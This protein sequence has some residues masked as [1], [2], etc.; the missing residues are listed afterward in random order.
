MKKIVLALVVLTAVL[1][2]GDFEDG[3]KA[4]DNKD[5]K[6]ATALWNKAA[7]EGDARAQF[8]IG[9]MSEGNHNH[10]KALKLYKQSCDGGFSI[11][12]DYYKK[13]NKK[14]DA[15]SADNKTFTVDGLKS[16]MSRDEIL[17]LKFKKRD[18]GQYTVLQGSTDMVSEMLYG[19]E[20]SGDFLAYESEILGK[21]A[22]VS[23]WFTTKTKLLYSARV[24][25]QGLGL[26]AMKN[27]GFMGNV[28]KVLTK[29][30][31]KGKTE[32]KKGK[33][34]FLPGTVWK[35][36]GQ[37]KITSRISIGAGYSVGVYINYLDSKLQ[38]QNENEKKSFVETTDKL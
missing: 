25:W 26:D 36:N 3:K 15:S 14:N 6:K 24:E 17:P 10:E 31:G 35:P 7:K 8:N 5:Y 32:I 18:D 33:E 30:Y 1:F 2:A 22:T 37:T 20:Q 19:K 27:T 11:G 9:F 28:N 4:F 38:K 29:K 12:C 16:G 21:K 23:L 13:L 34:V